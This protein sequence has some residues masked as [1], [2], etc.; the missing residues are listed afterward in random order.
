MQCLAKEGNI[1]NLNLKK[2]TSPLVTELAKAEFLR[3]DTVIHLGKC[4]ESE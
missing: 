3:F 4:S 1:Y 2:R